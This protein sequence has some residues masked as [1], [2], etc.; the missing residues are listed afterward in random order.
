[1]PFVEAGFLRD[2]GECAVAVVVVERVAVNSGDEEIGMTVVVVVADG[3]SNVEAGALQARL[4][5]DVGKDA[6]AIVAEEAI[7]VFGDVLLHGCE[8]GAV[9]KEDVGSAV[10]VVVEYR[11]A[12]G[13]GFRRVAGWTFVTVRG[14]KVTA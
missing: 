1:M 9:G 8:V 11:D 10:A 7:G 6:V 13:H 4:F 3:D 5:G 2:V 12:A 14:E